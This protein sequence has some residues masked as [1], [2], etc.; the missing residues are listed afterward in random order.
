MEVKE[1]GLAVKAGVVMEAETEVSDSE[2][3]RVVVDVAEVPAVEGSVEGLEAADSAAG[4]EA[5]GS[6]E[7]L[8]EEDSVAGLVAVGSEEDLAATGLAVGLVVAG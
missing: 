3:D 1:G 5:T 8:E 2:V 7:G 6:A 4:L